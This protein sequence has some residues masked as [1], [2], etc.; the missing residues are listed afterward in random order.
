[1]IDLSLLPPP[2]V[3]DPLDFEKILANHISNYLSRY[4]SD[5]QPIISERL[6]LESDPI[7]KLIQLISYRDI[8]WN[9]RVNEAAA[10][11]MLAYATG[12]DLDNLGANYDVRRLAGESDT[13]FRYRIQQAF[14]ILAAA[15]PAAAYRA[16]ARSVSSDV[17]DVNVFSEAAGQVTVCV[18]G[19]VFVAADQLALQREKIGARL[20]GAPNDANRRYVVADNNSELLLSVLSTLSAETVRPLT[21]WVVVRAPNI[22]PV[23]IEAVLEVLRGPDPSM[24]LNRRLEAIEIFLKSIQRIGYDITRAGI[25]AALV[26]AGVKNVRLSDPLE[27]VVCGQNDLAVV[28][29]LKIKTEVVDA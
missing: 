23:T 10:S 2:D 4:P 18:L 3:I 12:A 17:R 15:G 20:F 24:I 13:R 6:A 26:E 29:E 22:I 7:N 21:D 16:H 28:I 14:H 25:I 27:D 8:L 11:C 19:R 1:M 9:Q 5:A